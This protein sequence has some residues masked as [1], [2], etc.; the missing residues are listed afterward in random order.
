MS[1]GYLWCNYIDWKYSHILSFILFFH[2]RFHS[3]IHWFICS[4][5]LYSF[6]TCNFSQFFLFIHPSTHSNFTSHLQVHHGAHGFVKSTKG[7]PIKNAVIRIS[8][9]RHE[10][11][12]A[13]DGDYW[14][15][16]VP[17]SYDLTASAKG[18]EPQT[19]M[20]ELKSGETEK[21]VN[22]TLRSSAELRPKS[23]DL[24]DDFVSRVMV[25]MEILYAKYSDSLLVSANLCR[26]YVPWKEA[27]F[28]VF[29]N[30]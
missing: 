29:S 8:D 15:L 2:S 9:R 5:L 7:K 1:L 23:M 3:F 21:Y 17:G 12:T 27:L 25:S 13:K 14:R 22:F 4:S 30:P 26:H 19:K 10:V 18:Y 11:T 28:L 20:V 16:L 24:H 6:I